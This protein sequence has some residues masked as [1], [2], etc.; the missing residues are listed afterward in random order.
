MQIELSTPCV[1]TLRPK[2]EFRPFI[3]GL[4]DPLEPA[5]V[6]YVGMALQWKRPFAH[7]KRASKYYGNHFTEAHRVALKEAWVRRKAAKNG[8]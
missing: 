3:Y 7:A 2:A 6:R 8:R 4:V 5:H 1:Y